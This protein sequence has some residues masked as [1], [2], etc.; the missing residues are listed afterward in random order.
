MK[1]RTATLMLGFAALALSTSA[2]AGREWM[3][4]LPV[5]NCGLQS[6]PRE[7]DRASVAK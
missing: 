1:T 3:M 2:A 6:L 5:A 4:G 7:L